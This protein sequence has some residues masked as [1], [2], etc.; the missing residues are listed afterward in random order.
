MSLNP[1]VNRPTPRRPLLQRLS[2]VVPLFNEQ[3][4]MGELRRRLEA[5]RARMTC[6]LEI[7]LVDDGSSDRTAEL[8]EAWAAADPTVKSLCLAR[9]FGHQIALTAGLDVAT[10]EAVVLIDA[11]LQDPPELIP[12]MVEQYQLGHDVVYGRRTERPGETLFKRVSAALF[13]RLMRWLVHPDLPADTGDF[14]LMSRQVVQA[15][16]RMRERHRFLRG[17]VTWLGFSQ[18]SIPYVRGPREAGSTKY[19]LFKMCGLAWDAAISFSPSLLRLSMV[20]G[21]LV[22]LFGALYSLYSLY[23]AL[24]LKD[25]VPGWTTLVILV[26]LLGGW[27]LIAIGVL[28]EYLAK[29]YEELKQRPMYV[30]RK[31]VNCEVRNE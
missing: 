21:V 24:I 31:A 10:G 14:R 16:Q 30:V 4:V 5:L 13:Y 20:M 15:L 18:I 25:T 7:V 11:D 27:V 29:I 26:C 12:Q 8:A 19:G 3:E 23:H 2:I 17:M 9:N 28:G 22:A 1:S 6:P